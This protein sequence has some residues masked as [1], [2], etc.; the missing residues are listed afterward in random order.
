MSEINPVVVIIEVAS[1]TDLPKIYEGNIDDWEERLW[2]VARAHY[3]Q[4]SGDGT[5]NIHVD[6]ESVSHYSLLEKK[7]NNMPE[8]DEQSVKDQEQLYL[9]NY[10]A[11]QK[12]VLVFRSILLQCLETYAKAFHHKV[13]ESKHS[14]KEGEG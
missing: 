1:K 4:F 9:L 2:S 3:S 7:A 11:E 10:G 14:C 13:G 5:N 8:L 6:G 12:G